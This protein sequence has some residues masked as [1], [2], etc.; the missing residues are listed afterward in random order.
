[1][2]TITDEGRD[3]FVVL[4]RLADEV[5]AELLHPLDPHEQDVL[6]DLLAKVLAAHPALPA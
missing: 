4:R 3:H 6:R 5:Q 2:V 1:M